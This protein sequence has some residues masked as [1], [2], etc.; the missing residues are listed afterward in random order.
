MLDRASW[1]LPVPHDGKYDRSLIRSVLDEIADPENRAM[2]TREAELLAEA[3]RSKKQQ[4][5][6]E[7]AALIVGNPDRH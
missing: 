3:L 2:K 6:K 1:T 5:L 7:I 4:A